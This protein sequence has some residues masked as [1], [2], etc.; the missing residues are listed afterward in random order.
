MKNLKLD[1][2]K[3]IRIFDPTLCCPTGLC[4]VDINPELMRIAIVIDT[5][6]KKGIIIERFNLR[7]HP[8]VYVSNKAVNEYLMT[9]PDVL[10]ITMLGDQVVLRR[11]Y[12]TNQQLAEWLDI[13]EDE[14]MAKNEHT[15]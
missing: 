4:G 7:D 9:E 1:T 10:P 2:R 6:K 11:M 12:P 3:T 14:L 8:Q 13:A 5:L 15:K